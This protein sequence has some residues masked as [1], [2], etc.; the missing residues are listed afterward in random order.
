MIIR[1]DNI[2]I[3]RETID[4]IK[5]DLIHIDNKSEFLNKLVTKRLQKCS[6]LYLDNIDIKIN[7]LL[8]NLEDSDL[9]DIKKVINIV[10]RKYSD[11][12][13]S[14]L[15]LYTILNNLEQ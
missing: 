15:S 7:N 2:S 3:D 10:S 1:P 8:D 11:L 9:N 6:Q 5:K 4:N 13:R 12:Y 14:E